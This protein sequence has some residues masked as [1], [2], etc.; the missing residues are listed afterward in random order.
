[1]RWLSCNSANRHGKT[2]ATRKLRAHDRVCRITPTRTLLLRS[3]RYERR[4]NSM[5]RASWVVTSCACYA[6]TRFQPSR[7]KLGSNR[8]QSGSAG[9]SSI[10][11]MAAC[12]LQVSSRLQS[13]PTGFQKSRATG[14]HCCRAARLGQA[15][16]EFGHANNPVP[17]AQAVGV[18][19]L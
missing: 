14:V 17:L 6:Q 12:D 1:M 16:A 5:A 13:P 18:Q 2:F 3:T 10:C 9:P 8:S 11:R 15:S 4:F 19:G 7:K